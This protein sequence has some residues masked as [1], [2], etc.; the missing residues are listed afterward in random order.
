MKKGRKLAPTKGF[1]SPPESSSYPT[2]LTPA[3]LRLLI[4]A[5][6]SKVSSPC[7]F[8]TYFQVELLSRQSRPSARLSSELFPQ[9]QIPQGSKKGGGL[10]WPQRFPETLSSKL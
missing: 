2:L 1:S 4:P 10:H 9:V 6:K 5:D 3:P 7:P 8:I